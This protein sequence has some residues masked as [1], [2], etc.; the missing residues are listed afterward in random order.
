MGLAAAVST[1]QNKGLKVYYALKSPANSV[2]QALLA[3]IPGEIPVPW[4]KGGPGVWWL[5]ESTADGTVSASLGCPSQTPQAGGLRQQTPMFLTVPVA[6]S[7]RSGSQQ[8]VVSGGSLPGWQ[9]AACLLC[10]HMACALCQWRQRNL[11]WVCPFLEEL[12]PHQ[13]RAP[14]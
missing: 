5:V 7:P 8:G 13:L 11:W 9:R 14:P 3:P 4:S 12:Q 10:P 6:G 2:P 1:P